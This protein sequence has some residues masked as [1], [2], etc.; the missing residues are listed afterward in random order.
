MYTLGSNVPQV[1]AL[2]TKKDLPDARK[3]AI[4]AKR[5]PPP[6]PRQSVGLPQGQAL[7][8]GT[9]SKDAWP[10]KKECPE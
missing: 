9:S 7:S 4:S 1:I 8:P 5:I 10:A 2:R 6:S 3:Q